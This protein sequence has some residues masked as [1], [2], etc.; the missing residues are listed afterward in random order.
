[1]AP[2]SYTE[3]LFRLITEKSSLKTH[4]YNNTLVAFNLIKDVIK[5]LSTQFKKYQVK[6]KNELPTTFEAKPVG[7][8]EVDL[9]FGGDI[10]LFLMHTNVF[11]FSR[12]HEVMRTSYV[13]EDTTRSYCGVIN[14]Y[15]FIA[16]SFKYN[17]VN[18]VGYLIGRI[19][20]NKENHYFIEGKRELGFLYNNF[21]KNELTPDSV[22]EII[23]A[24]I[25]YTI[26]FDLL[27]PHYDQVKFVTVNEIKNT[28]DSISIK[29]GKRIGY[30][31]QADDGGK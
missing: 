10:L 3:E 9:K 28:L 7:K 13:K 21:G 26:N 5:D 12:N 24:A 25:K 11:E 2:K 6:H 22:E 18:D 23:K 20:I 4:V 17:R 19:F 27:T 29:T 1:M 30:K 8:F 16:D 31:F 14:I 15:N